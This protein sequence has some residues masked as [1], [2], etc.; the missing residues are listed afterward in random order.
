MFSFGYITINNNSLAAIDQ[1][2]RD[3]EPLKLRN[4]VQINKNRQKIFPYIPNLQYVI[5]LNSVI[6]HKKQYINYYIFCVIILHHVILL[7]P[8]IKSYIVTK[9]ATILKKFIIISYVIKPVWP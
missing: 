1:K 5:L 4:F 6:I 7:H 8:E 9:H 3:R 2:G